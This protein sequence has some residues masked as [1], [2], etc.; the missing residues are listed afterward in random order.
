MHQAFIQTFIGQES[1]DTMRF[2]PRACL[3]ELEPGITN[4]IK[5]SAMCALFKPDNM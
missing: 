2:V 5:A 1:E 3:I 4:V